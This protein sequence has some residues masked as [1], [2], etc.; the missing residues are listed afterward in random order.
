MNQHERIAIVGM[1][2]VLPDAL[3]VP[4][5]WNNMLTRH[6]S[7]APV[8]EQIWPSF[9]FDPSRKNAE[10][11]YSRLG[12]VVKGLSFHA[13]EFGL[14]PST[15]PQLDL[16]QKAALLASRQALAD[17][18]IRGPTEGL[19]AA[20]Y[21]GNLQGGTQAK[22][23]A[24]F[25]LLHP[26][27]EETVA[28]LPSVRGLPEAVRGSLTEELR[29]SWYS[30][31]KSVD[32]DSL[33]GLLGN[34]T[35]SRV[36]HYFNFQGP[37]QVVDAACAS[38]LAAVDNS[39]RLL[40][41]GKCDL[42]VTGAVDFLMDIPSYVG[43]CLMGAL[44]AEGS[45]PFDRRA[46]GF[47]MGEG[48]AV[49]VLKR[50]SDARAAGDRIYAV[51][52]GIGSSSDGR[53]RSLVAPN[54]DGQ[55][56]AM[57]EAYRQA[58]V[59]PATVGYIEAHGTATPL[60]DPVEIHGMREIF[61]DAGRGQLAIGSVKGNLGHLKGAAGAVGLLRAALALHED[62]LPPHAG[63]ETP[64]P[65]CELES[66]PFRVPREPQ[67]WDSKVRRSA[68]SAFG[69][70][71]INY[72][73]VL[74]EAEPGTARKRAPRPTQRPGLPLGLGVI[75][76]GANSRQDLLAELSRLRAEAP[77]ARALAERLCA[78]PL[79]GEAPV[80]L[81]FFAEDAESCARCLEAAGTFLEK[82]GSTARLDALG[83]SFR[84]GPV[85][86]GGVAFMF[87]GQG[88]QYV[89]MLDELRK[90]YPLVQQ[91]LDEADEV[92]SALLPRKLS[93]YLY[94]EPGQDPD[95]AFIELT[96]TEILQ[97]AMLA[98][99]EALR[100]LLTPLVTPQLVMGHSLGEYGACVAAGVLQ[101]GQALKLVSARGDAMANVKTED[102]GLMLGVGAGEAQVQQLLQGIEG[103]AVIVNKNCHTQTI[104]GGATAAVEAADARMKAAGLETVFLPVSH[105]FHS[106][107]V[108]PASEPL[109]RELD[110]MEVK[111]PR[112]PI[113]SNVT[114]DYYPDGPSATEWIRATLAQQLASPV[115]FIQM[116]ERAYADGVRTFIEVGPKRAQAGFVSDILKGRPHRSLHL[117]HPKLGE[118]QTLGRAMASLVAD[119]QVPYGDP[120]A[121]RSAPAGEVAPRPPFLPPMLPMKP[122]APA[123]VAQPAAAAV[124][125]VPLMGSFAVLDGVSQD[126]RFWQ[127]VA[128]QAPLLANYLAGSY[129]AALSLAPGAPALQALPGLPPVAPE[130]AP[131]PA[132]IA[133]PASVAPP[134]APGPIT[135][136]TSWVLERVAAKTGYTKEEL[137]LD[138]QLES[139]LGVD[140]IR[141][142][143][144][145]MSLRDEL[146]LPPDD[147][148]RLSDYP[149]LRKL[150]GYLEQRMAAV[151]GAPPPGA[152]IPAASASPAV[153]LTTRVLQ[154]VVQKTGYE[155]SELQQ[156]L[157]ANLESELGI[158]SIRQMEV[159]LAL[160]EEF[161]FTGDDGFRLS[162]YPT[163]RS[164]IAYLE[165]R[166]GG[167]GPQ[168]PFDVARPAPI[169]EPGDAEPLK[170]PLFARRL[171][172]E[173][174]P[175]ALS[176]RHRPLAVLC[177]D[178]DP[179]APWQKLPGR[180]VMIPPS[181]SEDEIQ[182]SLGSLEG[183][184]LVDACALAPGKGSAT[185]A[186][187]AALR[188]VFR[189]ARAISRSPGR[190]AR[191][192]VLT[193]MGGGLG[194]EPGASTTTEA[195]AGSAAAAGAW[196]SVGR[197]WSE[198]KTHVAVTVADLSSSPTAEDLEALGAELSAETGPLEVAFHQGVRRAPVLRAA[199]LSQGELPRGGVVLLVGG[200][201]GILSRASLEL[202]RAGYRLAL[203][204]RTPR[205]SVAAGLDRTR[206][207]ALAREKAGAGASTSEVNRQAEL[208][209]RQ[210]E[211]EATLEELSRMG[212][213]VLYL[214][215]DASRPEEMIAAVEEVR[216]RFGRL[217]AVIH[218]AGVDQSKSLLSKRE[219]ELD[220]VL[221]PK[222]AGL[223]AL[224]RAAAPA[225][226]CTIGSVTGRF[227]NAG[228]IDYGAANEVLSKLCLAFG[229]TALDFTAWA[230][231]GMAVVFAPV[232]RERGMDLLP[233]GEGVK[234]LRAAVGPGA[235]GEWVIC[236]RLPGVLAFEPPL[237]TR[238][239]LFVP[240]AERVDSFSL[241]MENC[242]FL[243]DHRATSGGLLP[244]VVGL[245]L[246]AFAARTVA[247]ELPLT[248]IRGLSFAA[249]L[250]VFADKPREATVRAERGQAGP[251]GLITRAHIQVGDTLHHRAELLL[252]GA[253]PVPEAPTARPTAPGPDAEAIYRFFFHGPS[254]QAV[255]STWM[256]EHMLLARSKPLRPP[257]GE[258]LAPSARVRAMAREVALQ[259]AGIFLWAARKQAGLPVGI[260][261]VHILQEAREGEQVEATA[262]PRSHLG[263]ASRFDVWL[264]GDDGRLLE[265]W[266]GLEFQKLADV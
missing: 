109:R 137:D 198:E 132:P 144:V 114:G 16:S 201:R 22:G 90:R 52:R 193:R 202:A 106:A 205:G 141:Q 45:F 216:R 125:L 123:P 23:E 204:G 46:N 152:P 119:G 134:A 231:V 112:V 32:G 38:G 166:V 93:S 50:L 248:S 68:V 251:E 156:N 169:A 47:I 7:I 138:S 15:E 135:D 49:F 220:Q 36:A 18:G 221:L 160:R 227:G 176:A 111:A 235:P 213:E 4:A 206:I 113:L 30:Q 89:G 168:R 12:S 130:A 28:R 203:V 122:T 21:F 218:G 165:E 25:R 55:M 107:I 180:K 69:F 241:A 87:P 108:S 174:A 177:P 246:M 215:A 210:A 167:G 71:G 170:A 230:D 188:R 74:E 250:K 116:V 76:L 1:G 94:V 237:P 73:V 162:N 146:Q 91:A 9:L 24:W 58:G 257:L 228:Q 53:G 262:A 184:N 56:R 40:L 164:L 240:G 258:D 34:I 253:L 143:D 35:A 85:V 179:E 102:P 214:S 139:E 86:G 20:V 194:L 148:F 105:A 186:A 2:A 133:P 226:L 43:F 163:L 126:P 120:T 83:I 14:A 192:V 8:P 189:V 110:K 261:Q 158:D 142:I 66:S 157:D 64:N 128:M 62:T 212:A 233:P 39:C 207:R 10:R 249:P 19:N 129:R 79:L 136:F 92:M 84:E 37:A 11:P 172:L 254:F 263:T 178:A 256:S 98:C 255:E 234:I 118:V 117:C 209:T 236:G 223:E 199:A 185:A 217:D 244:G 181:M 173:A 88:S 266:S 159:L 75:A 33:P 51:I 6:C 225:K 153:E 145:A 65:R 239:Q 59:D 175:P 29:A 147:R 154:R 17:Y 219:E 72:H 31:F 197:E 190:P 63:F 200:A 124:P 232:M 196:K 26:V 222:V 95:D 77:S 191:V 140:S 208:L 211:V 187:Q 252:G 5:F 245:E 41:S 99:D 48:A 67:G 131:A 82:G 115:E 61:K 104:V 155:L 27:L 81:A 260:Q 149:T 171:F 243:R 127:F 96:R 44:S 247:P 57:S 195:L 60:G 265:A 264:R 100:R 259:A 3:D 238:N 121:R 161:K 151:R 13:K 101:F 78:R 182:Q 103:Y 183:V 97:P 54:P 70:G 224:A 150:I 242:A 80:R 229:G 42:A